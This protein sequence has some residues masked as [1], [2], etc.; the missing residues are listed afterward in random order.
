[1]II[2]LEILILC[3]N[4]NF[5]QENVHAILEFLLFRCVLRKF[6]ECD[7]HTDIQPNH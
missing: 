1:M 7:K 2:I 3:A 4:S 6:F 5:L